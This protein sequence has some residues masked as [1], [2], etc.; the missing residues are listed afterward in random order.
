MICGSRPIEYTRRV[1]RVGAAMRRYTTNSS[2]H[3]MNVAGLNIR[4]SVSIGIRQS[5]IAQ[6][7]RLENLKDSVRGRFVHAGA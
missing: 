3:W 6:I 5:L 7:A 4:D 2:S 1:Y